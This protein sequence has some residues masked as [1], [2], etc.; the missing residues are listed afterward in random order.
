MPHMQ[1][2]P[3]RSLVLLFEADAA[4]QAAP[5]HTL[6]AAETELELA[7]GR[8]HK[9]KNTGAAEP[10]PPKKSATGTGSKN[11]WHKDSELLLGSL[12]SDAGPPCLRRHRYECALMEMT[13]APPTSTSPQAGWVHTPA[14]H[15]SSQFP[16]LPGDTPPGC[17]PHPM[18][19]RTAIRSG[20]RHLDS[21]ADASMIGNTKLAC[22]PSKFKKKGAGILSQKVGRE[23]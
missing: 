2:R 11:K 6:A 14:P 19:S 9:R 7:G 3:R 20:W 22:D 5:M 21:L 12:S 10:P 16:K 4:F 1:A 15:R 23:S 13:A 18:A 8:A 17:G